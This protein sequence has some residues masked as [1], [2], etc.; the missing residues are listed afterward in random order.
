VAAQARTVTRPGACV[1]LAAFSVLAALAVPRPAAAGDWVPPLAGPLQVIH[2]FAPPA[3]R[4]SAGHRGVD[5]AG[6]PGT[7]VRAA[8]AGRVSFA[9]RL[10]GRGVVVV[11]HGDG[12]RTT[13]EPVTPA[14]TVGEPVAAG[15]TIGLLAGNGSHCLPAACLHWGHLDGVVYLDPMTLLRARPVRLLPVWQGTAADASAG[16]WRAPAVAAA[17]A[18]RRADS[19]RG[20]DVASGLAGVA[21]TSGLALALGR[22]VGRRPPAQSSDGRA[23]ARRA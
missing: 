16:A 3:Q 4:W 1:L 13:Y 8:G 11:G 20:R 6:A 17:G 9:G 10:A 5:L 21:A 14:V 18:T 12:T 23:A 15:G 7:V 19:G 2:P 22:R